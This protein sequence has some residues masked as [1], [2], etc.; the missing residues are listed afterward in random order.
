MVVPITD[1]VNPDNASS[2]IIQL[3]GNDTDLPL[4]KIQGAAAGTSIPATTHMVYRRTTAEKASLVGNFVI[5][6]GQVTLPGPIVVIFYGSV[7]VN[8]DITFNTSSKYETAE[9]TCTGNVSFVSGIQDGEGAI[10]AGNPWRERMA[11]C[12]I[13]L[14]VIEWP[15]SHS[16][17]I[18]SAV[19]REGW[20]RFFLQEIC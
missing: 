12:S 10:V 4:A 7:Q 18:Q 3:D 13:I 14:P 20:P 9:G 5:A 8:M 1:Q 2:L 11:R 15:M 17:Y 19:V 16:F 6:Q